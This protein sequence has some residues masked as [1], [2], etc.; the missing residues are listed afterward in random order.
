MQRALRHASGALARSRCQAR[1]PASAGRSPRTCAK[2]IRSCPHA[3]A[4][5]PPPVPGRETRR[6]SRCQR[7]SSPSG[8]PGSRAP[9]GSPPRGYP[10]PCP[11]RSQTCA[12]RPRER[13]RPALPPR[14]ERRRNGARSGPRVLLTVSEKRSGAQRRDHEP[15]LGLVALAVRLDVRAVRQVGMHRLALGGAHRL[16]LDRT[17][18][19]EGLRGSAIGL[20]LERLLAALAVTRRVDDDALALVAIMEGR[21][22]RKVLQRVDRLAVAP[23]QPAHLVGPLDRGANLIV[24][25]GH[26]DGG[27]E[28]K[29]LDDAA[30]HLP[31]ALDRLLRDLTHRRRP[32][33]FFF[34]RRPGGGD[35]ASAPL[36]PSLEFAHFADFAASALGFAPFPGFSVTLAP[37]AAAATG[38]VGTHFFIANC[39]PMVQT[40]VVIQ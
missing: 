12:D 13:G 38:S 22:P 19:A 34:L 33:R 10:Q 4:G 17:A 30:D 29:R 14:R 18:V 21:A 28:P 36:D 39:C 23:D 8:L 35:L 25:L 11:G 40:F 32:E 6:P 7:S 2:R 24:G 9:T 15:A 20:A 3:P 5:A 1:P 16:E 31:D 27:V 26:L 37:P